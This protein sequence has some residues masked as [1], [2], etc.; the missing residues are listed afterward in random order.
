MAR[1][2]LDIAPETTG[3]SVEELIKHVY[4]LLET[5][6]LIS[7]SVATVVCIDE[8]NE[9]QFYGDGHNNNLSARQIENFEEFNKTL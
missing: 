6:I 8:S 5:D 1:F 9:N 3:V 2:I 4:G 7:K